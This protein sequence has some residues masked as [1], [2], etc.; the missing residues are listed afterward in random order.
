V[1]LAGVTGPIA[2]DDAEDLA[3]MMVALRRAV[4]ASKWVEVLVDEAR[5]AALES[6]F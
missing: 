4:P 5:E 3:G 2:R 6:L 1:R